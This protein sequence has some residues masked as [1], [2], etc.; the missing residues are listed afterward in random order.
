MRAANMPKLFL[1]WERSLLC[2]LVVSIAFLGIGR[3]SFAGGA[4]FSAW[5]ISRTTF[6]FWLTWKLALGVHFGWRSV[7][8]NHP[9]FLTP[10]LIFLAAATASLLPDFRQAADYRYLFFA[11]MHCVMVV[12]LFAQGERA[13]LLLLLLGLLPG[14]LV[15]RG[16]VSDP[17]V[18]NFSLDHRFGYPLTHANAAGLIFAMSIP[19]GLAVLATH[20]DRLRTVAAASLAAQF[21]GLLLTYSRGAWLGCGASLLGVGLLDPR[22]KKSAF[23]LGLGGLVA[24]AAV[25]PLRD[26]LLSLIHPTADAAI[27]DRLVYMES[28]WTVGIENPILG[29]GYGRDRLREGVKKEVDNADEIGFM[30]HS[31]NMYTELLAETGVVGLAAFLWMVGANLVAL[32]RRARAEISAHARLLYF[33]LAASLLAFLVA[34]LGD[35]PFYNH[36]TRIFFFTLLPLTR[37]LLRREDAERQEQIGFTA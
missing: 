20:K 3:T 22:L 28:A 29:Y 16:I 13:K 8:V 1:W 25:A 24:F 12:D 32:I 11:V 33:A 4:S 17:S 35:A 9:A 36:D 26:R 14:V 7:R 18:L 31:H 19:L 6:F 23:A 37:L 34:I 5:S 15:I 21:I 27:A 30:P 2:A 10:I